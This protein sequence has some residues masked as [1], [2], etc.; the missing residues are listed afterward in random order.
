MGIAKSKHTLERIALVAVGVSLAAAWLW[1]RMEPPAGRETDFS[2][3]RI[4]AEHLTAPYDIASYR[5][6]HP[7]APGTTLFAYPPTFLLLAYPFSLLPYAVGLFLWVGLSYGLFLLSASYLHLRAAWLL[8]IAPFGMILG[9]GFGLPFLHE[10]ILNG[11]STGQTAHWT[12]A[13][14]IAAGLLLD[15]RP[16]LAGALLAVVACIKPT[17]ALIAPFVLLGRWRA[18]WSSILVGVGLIVATLPLGPHL[19]LEWYSATTAF[20]GGSYQMQPAALFHN[21][22]WQVALIAIGIVFAVTNRQL[23]A[24]LVGAILCTP[25]LMPY[26]LA[27]LCALGTMWIAQARSNWL[28]AAAGSALLLGLVDTALATTV[29]G[30]VVMLSVMVEQ[31]QSGLASWARSRQG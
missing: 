19:W 11:I 3:F 10:P 26:D 8:V 22:A 4:A 14:L 9:V 31:R 7:K 21:L 29:V 13:G 2:V 27:A 24:L 28:L 16:A 23:P 20:S 17:A 25:Y 12:A 5:E 1:F 15:R 18:L 6:L 30:L